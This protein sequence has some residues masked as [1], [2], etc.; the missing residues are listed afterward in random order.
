LQNFV[1]R[2]IVY[3]KQ[4]DFKQSKKLGFDRQVVSEMKEILNQYTK[5]VLCI[6]GLETYIISSEFYHELLNIIDSI[7]P[8]SYF[9]KELYYYIE[10]VSSVKNVELQIGVSYNP[11][12][13][14]ESLQWRPILCYKHDKN[15]YHVSYKEKWRC[16]DCKY[17]NHAVIM[18]LVDAE[19]D[20]YF[21]AEKPAYSPLFKKIPCKKCG[22]L[23]QGYLIEV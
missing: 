18:Q 2:L 13:K 14:I 15:L 5:E 19:P 11:H 9:K 10:V 21:G 20:V 3:L 22:H 7:Q 8:N 17:D 6:D 4:N 1:N 23:L 12:I 16:F